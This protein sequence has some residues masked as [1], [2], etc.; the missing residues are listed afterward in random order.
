MLANRHIIWIVV[1]ITVCAGGC[2]SSAR[3]E[4]RYTTAN[5]VA[6]DE[7]DRAR[8][9]FQ[10]GRA[11]DAE[12]GFSSF[13]IAHPEDSLRP[14]AELY[15]GRIAEAEGNHDEAAAWLELAA[16]S[17]D[18]ELAAAARRELGASLL[19][20]GQAERA[21]A[22]LEPLA[23]RLDGQAAADLY[24]TL[25][26][27]ASAANDPSRQIRFLDAWCRYGGRPACAAARPRVDECVGQLDEETLNRLHDELPRRGRGWGSTTA[28]LGILA[29]GRGDIATAV[30][31]LEELEEANLA[32]GSTAGALRSAIEQLERIDW[33]AI[34][35]LLPLTGRA[36]L[37]GEQMR[38]GLELAAGGDDPLRLVVR[39]TAGG[40]DSV[41]LAI[42]ELVESERVAAIV[43]PVDSSN[44]EIAARRA[45]ELGVPLLSLTIRPGVTGAGRWILRAFQTNEADVRAL[46]TQGRNGLGH[47]RFAVLHP[48]NGYGRVLRDLVEREVVEQGGIFEVAL[49][50]SP[51]QT[52]FVPLCQELAQHDFDALVIPA[53]SRTIALIAP[54][55]ASSG[56]WSIEPN[57]SPPEEGRPVQ[58]LLPSIAFSEQLVRQTGRYLQ[59]TLFA[60]VLWTGDP[61]DEV[62]RFVQTYRDDQG[63]VP[64]GWVSQAHDAAQI[65]RAAR[66]TAPAHTREGLLE[67]LHALE[68]ATTV[69]SFTGFEPNGEPR[70]PLR[71][72]RLEGNEFVRVEQ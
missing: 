22:I 64:T 45:Q 29:A 72:L 39:D 69:G 41:V 32:E 49:S 13:I 63:A 36:R 65:I 54:A 44:A 57:G 30:E 14:A 24:E 55:L 46:V 4:P 42:D 34:G 15:L 26:G 48:D 47:R 3:A 10:S 27:A 67:S 9:L 38:S 23:G 53:P 7:F 6:Q 56:L 40:P 31:R 21:L 60:N 37:V 2:S 5:P 43:G 28:R 66:A 25:A 68:S 58:L 61:A 33:T 8:E 19:G 71:L 17:N 51:G 35:A 20:A 16:A 11:T 62:S 1:F 12:Q 59:G 50:Y 52:S 18:Q 70:T